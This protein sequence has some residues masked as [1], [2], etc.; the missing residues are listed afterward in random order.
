MFIKGGLRT[1]NFNQNGPNPND[2][3][4][5]DNNDNG[6]YDNYFGLADSDACID[7]SA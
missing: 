1:L 3:P 2:D 4:E 7:A 5:P 6:Y